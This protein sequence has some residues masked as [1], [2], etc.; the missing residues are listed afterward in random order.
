M[1]TSYNIFIGS[2]C[3]DEVEISSQHPKEDMKP[4]DDFKAS[5]S[6]GER[7]LFKM[8]SEYNSRKPSE[9]EDEWDDYYCEEE[10]FY[11]EEEKALMDKYEQEFCY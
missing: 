5:L 11:T 7:K 3:V 10:D 2:H 4:F 1:A 8:V 9:K 6:E